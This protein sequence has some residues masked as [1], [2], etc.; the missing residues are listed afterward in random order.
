MGQGTG[1]VKAGAVLLLQEKMPNECPPSPSKHQP[2]W[3]CTR[4]RLMSGA[5]E[6]SRSRAASSSAL[7]AAARAALSA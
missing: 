2:T 4:R 3:A 7:A 6:H 5:K 1:A